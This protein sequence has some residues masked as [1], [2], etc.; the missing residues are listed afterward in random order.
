VRH[1]F[2]DFAQASTVISRAA[3]SLEALEWMLVS[4]KVSEAPGL[5]P[6]SETADRDAPFLLRG[7]FQLLEEGGWAIDYDVTPVT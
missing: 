7:E 5:G 2:D 6:G 3:L 4:A 1:P